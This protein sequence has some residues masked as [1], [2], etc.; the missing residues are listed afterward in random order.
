MRMTA[1]IIH[2][3]QGLAPDFLPT[4]CQSAAL[5][6][7]ISTLAAHSVLTSGDYIDS[8]R[9]VR[10]HIPW[11]ADLWPVCSGRFL[12][13]RYSDPANME[14]RRSCV[15]IRSP[16]ARC[17]LAE[18]SRTLGMHSL[19][20]TSSQDMRSGIRPGG[21]FEVG[22]GRLMGLSIGMGIVVVVADT[23]VG[24]VVVGVLVFVALMPRLGIVA[25]GRC[26]VSCCGGGGRIRSIPQ[27]QSLRYLQLPH[28]L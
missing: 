23:F 6:H 4:R 12:L 16:S 17:D 14:E 25:V 24:V 3:Y 21:K 8:A 19:G 10:A 7:P 26:F 9:L 13:L 11:A 20:E 18:A 1:S 5:L 28:Q 2:H 27:W 15:L 22:L